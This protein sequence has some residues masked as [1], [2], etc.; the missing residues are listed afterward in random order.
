MVTADLAPL[1]GSDRLFLASIRGTGWRCVTASAQWPSTGPVRAIFVEP[2]SVVDVTRDHFRSLASRADRVCQ[3]GHP[4]LRIRSMRIR[5]VVS[6]G[7]V[8]PVPACAA[9]AV[10]RGCDADELSILLGVEVYATPVL[11]E[12]HGDVVPEPSAFARYAAPID[13]RD[14]PDLFVEGEQVRVSELVHGVMLRVGLVYDTPTRTCPVRFVGNG[15]TAR[16]LDGANVYSRVARRAVD[17]RWLRELPAMLGVSFFRHF[18]LYLQVYGGGVADLS[19]GHPVDRQSCLLLDVA[20][21]GKY[22]PWVYLEHV[23]AQLSIPRVPLIYRGP[24]RAA[25]LPAWREGMTLLGGGHTRKGCVVVP[26]PEGAVS[27][28]DGPMRRRAGK[29][30]AEAFV[31]RTQREV[32]E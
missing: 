27:L 19:Y 3:D 8:I 31:L 12:T 14:A 6:E 20:S 29:S 2:E 16:S 32:R 30:L 17:D 5:G 21:D 15:S 23:A 1:E 28:G 13:A 22:L 4:G 26:E 11:P 7:L 9:E 25:S 10:A 18:V 24:Y